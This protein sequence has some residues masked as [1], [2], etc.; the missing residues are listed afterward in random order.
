LNV[1]TAP[2]ITTQPTDQTVCAGASASFSVSASGANLTFQWRKGGTPLSNG[3]N[4]SGAASPALTI[5]N[6]S[7][8]DAGLNFY[9]VVVSGSCGFP[10]FSNPASLSVNTAP[11]VITQPTDQTVCP[12]SVTFVAAANG[13]P[14]PGVQWQEKVNGGS[15]INMPGPAAINPTLTFAAETSDDGNQYRAVF[16]NSCGSTTTNPASLTVTTPMLTI[17]SRLRSPLT[18]SGNSDGRVVIPDLTNQVT[19]VSNCGLAISSS[20]L[21][22]PGTQVGPVP[23]PVTITIRDSAG[24]TVT[25]ESIIN[26]DGDSDGIEASIDRNRTSQAIEG[27]IPSNDFVTRAVVAPAESSTSGTVTHRS[28]QNVHVIPSSVAGGV[29]ASISGGTFGSIHPLTSINAFENPLIQIGL[30]TSGQIADITRKYPAPLCTQVFGGPS[31]LRT[32]V[33]ALQTPLLHPIVIAIPL[34][35]NR[36]TIDPRTDLVFRIALQQRQTVY[37]GSPITADPANQGN[38]EIEILHNTGSVLGSLQLPP[39]KT[40]DIDQG[41]SRE[42]VVTNLDRAPLMLTFNGIGYTLSPG[43]ALRPSLGPRAIYQ[44]V[45]NDVTALGEKTNDKRDRE[46]LNKAITHLIAALDRQLSTD[47]FH[48]Q[49]KGGTRV[50]DEAK[51]AVNLLLDLTKNKQGSLPDITTQ[52]FVNA[53]VNANRQLADIAINEAVAARGA[54]RRI[55]E[56]NEELK[57]GDRD[58]APHLPAKFKSAIDHYR[59]AWKHSINAA[60]KR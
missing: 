42:L 36:L 17:T 53:L 35:R 46:K 57:R 6:T 19:A 21:P 22:I 26:S 11:I 41:A 27:K 52:A 47:A 40:V 54:Q 56:A 50:F 29:Q 20:Q 39:G 12:G 34:P 58:L 43:Q 33:Q 55:N 15:F 32:R 48:L 44:E 28:D 25:S 59:E 1:N 60:A 16:T 37:V 13:S 2:S 49:R 3:P 4:I 24:N 10:A 51:D 8:G 23:T 18:V 38:I 5:N 7:A 30:D 9:D 31:C 14:A 45:L